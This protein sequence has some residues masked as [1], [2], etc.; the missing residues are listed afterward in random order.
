MHIS[1]AGGKRNE[2]EKKELV[3]IALLAFVVVAATAAAATA[4]VARGE[5]Y[6]GKFYNAERELGDSKSAY[7]KPNTLCSHHRS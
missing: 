6:S 2:R 1:R 3:E 7:N 5:P 4:A